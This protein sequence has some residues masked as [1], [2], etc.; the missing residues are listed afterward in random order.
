MAASF[1]GIDLPLWH[2]ETKAAPTALK[3]I[4]FPGVDGEQALDMGKDG[5]PLRVTGR[6]PDAEGGATKASDIDGLDT[7]ATGTLTIG[8]RTFTKVRPENP[9]THSYTTW[10]IDGVETL[11]C[12]YSIDF[13][14]MQGA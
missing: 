12:L 6:L 2:F 7:G 8:S 11:T 1:E 5:R 13:V 14:Q 4:K 10:T 9:H 3:P